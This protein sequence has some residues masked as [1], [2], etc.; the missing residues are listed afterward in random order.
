MIKLNPAPTFEQDVLL[1]V[2]G[3]A[4]PVTVPMTFKYMTAEQVLAWWKD[5][6]G[7]PP[8]QAIPEIVVGWGPQAVAADDGTHVPYSPEALATLIKNYQP[9][10][11]EILRAWQLGLTESRIKN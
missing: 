4:A 2:P 8:A 9:A 5:K 10:T 3:Q 6:A 1:T 11:G 7:T